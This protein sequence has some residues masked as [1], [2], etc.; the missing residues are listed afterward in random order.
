M[1][2]HNGSLVALL[3]LD[4]ALL[5][6][7]VCAQSADSSSPIK[8]RIT[9]AQ[10]KDST[11]ARAKTVRLVSRSTIPVGSSP[12][13]V[14]DGRPTQEPEFKFIDPNDIDKIE[15][16]KGNTAT[17]IYGSR[18]TNGVILVTTKHPPAKPWYQPIT[19]K[20]ASIEAAFFIYNLGLDYPFAVSVMY[21]IMHSSSE[22]PPCWN[23]SL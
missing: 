20:A 15:R 2:L 11:K 5:P 19:K 14:V 13:Y 21:G 12:L 17:A 1:F 9:V 3:G 18:A 16:L 7:H 23:V 22:I 6:S 4:T 8:P 10:V